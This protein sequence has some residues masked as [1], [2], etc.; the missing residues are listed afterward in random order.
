MKEKNKK[1]NKTAEHISG[2]R[3]KRNKQRKKTVEELKWTNKN[4]SGE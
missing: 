4:N 1:S 3:I 2:N